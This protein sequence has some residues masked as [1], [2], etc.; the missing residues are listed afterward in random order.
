MAG[1][2]A[3]V[4]RTGY[5]GEDG[6]ELFVAGDDAVAVWDALLARA[7]TATCV[8]CGLGARDTLR[9]EAGMP[10][11]GNELDRDCTPA[12][13]GPGTG[14]QAGQARRLR[15]PRRARGAR[16]RALASRSWGSMLR[17]PGIARHGYPVYR[18]GASPGAPSAAVTSGTLSPT[19][20]AAIAMA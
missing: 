7:P 20:G 2:G 13:A 6:F 17:E 10:L 14:G 11:Y 15:G 9:L 16:V 1:V 12:E 8:P 4:A 3:V 18:R 19:L 5:T